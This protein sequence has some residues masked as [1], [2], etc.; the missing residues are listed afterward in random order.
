MLSHC[1]SIS[2]LVEYCQWE[3]VNLT[4]PNPDEVLVLTAARYGR[5]QP[6]RCVSRSYGSVGCSAD[7][8]GLMDAVCS[9]RYSCVLLVPDE[10]LREMRPCPKDFAAYLELSYRCVA[11][12]D[13]CDYQGRRQESLTGGGGATFFLNS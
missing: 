9:G 8:L 5:M 7:V 4:C 13:D 10:R 3:T 1:R 12:T 11:G 6:G 2:E